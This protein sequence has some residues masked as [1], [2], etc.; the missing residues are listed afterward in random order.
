MNLNY[1]CDLN[2]MKAWIETAEQNKY[3]HNLVIDYDGEVIL[4]PEVKYPHVPLYQYKYK[5]TIMDS[6]LHVQDMGTALY[7]ALEHIFSRVNG[8]EH[9]SY[10]RG[11]MAA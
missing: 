8:E 4:D 7:D 2:A 1:E 9:M 3:E 5:M 6:I 10:R 11:G